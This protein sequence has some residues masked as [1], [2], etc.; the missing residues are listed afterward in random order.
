MACCCPGPSHHL[1]QCWL[2]LPFANEV[3]GGVYWFY[4]VHLSVCRQNRVS[5]VSSTILAGSS[6]CLHIFIKHVVAVA[7]YIWLTSRSQAKIFKMKEI[8]TVS[9]CS[10]SLDCFTLLLARHLTDV[11]C[12]I[13]PIPYPM[14]RNPVAD[15]Y[16][17]TYI[18]ASGLCCGLGGGAW[19][20]QFIVC[21]F[22]ICLNFICLYFI[23]L[24]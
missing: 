22:F 18:S 24:V 15:V 14:V 5:S 13:G 3:G 19:W 1:N 23:Y 16:A 9:V 12:Y 11:S 8:E 4:C 21:L 10:R 7:A 17:G 6:S 2:I 20:D